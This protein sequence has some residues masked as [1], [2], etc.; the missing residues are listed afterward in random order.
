MAR[1]CQLTSYTTWTKRRVHHSLLFLYKYNT[2]LPIVYQHYIRQ[3]SGQSIHA[4]CKH[5]TLLKVLTNK[6][7]TNIPLP[8]GYLNYCIHTT[9]ILEL[10]TIQNATLLNWLYA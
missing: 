9:N 4:F 5:E 1:P 7:N 3:H 10:Q 2:R 8:Y 6:T